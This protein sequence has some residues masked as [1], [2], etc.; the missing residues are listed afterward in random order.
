V[1]QEKNIQL[2]HD[3]LNSPFL[4]KL[5]YSFNTEFDLVMVTPFLKGGDLETSMWR[6]RVRFLN[7][8]D[9]KF[10][11]AEQVLGLQA[12]HT[13]RII[14]MDVKPSNVLSRRRECSCDVHL[15]CSLLVLPY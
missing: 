1:E 5:L 7:H 6:R 11:A 14:H 9:F 10:Y 2:M 15:Y 8:D 13:C 3:D 4:L 12:L